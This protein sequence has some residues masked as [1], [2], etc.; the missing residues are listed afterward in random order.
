[1]VCQA[2]KKDK[3]CHFWGNEGCTFLGGQCRPVV[4]RCEGCSRVEEWSAGRYCTSYPLPEKR[5]TLGLC[6]LATHIKIGEESV[7]KA[8]NPLKASKRKAGAR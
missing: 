4:E 7:Q 1:M 2:I 8:L 6:N 3:D 5:W